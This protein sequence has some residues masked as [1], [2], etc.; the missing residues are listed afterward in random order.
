MAD[1][2]TYRED[3]DQ[4]TYEGTSLALRPA[5]AGSPARRETAGRADLHSHHQYHH[6]RSYSR[7]TPSRAD[8]RERD[9]PARDRS[10]SPVAVDRDG[11][12]DTRPRDEP[13][14]GRAERSA[15]PLHTIFSNNH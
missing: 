1:L 7:L 8:D 5:R 4:R 15:C 12:I 3:G 2:D 9:Y 6:H 11:D 13:S 14:N 10:R